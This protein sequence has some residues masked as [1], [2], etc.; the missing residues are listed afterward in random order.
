MNDYAARRSSV[1]ICEIVPSRYFV[2][3]ARPWRINSKTCQGRATNRPLMFEDAATIRQIVQDEWQVI[4]QAPINFVSAIILGLIGIWLFLRHQYSERLE[5]TKHTLQ[6]ITAQRDSYRE[7]REEERRKNA[8]LIDRLNTSANAANNMDGTRSDGQTSIV[9]RP[10]TTATE[11][12]HLRYR[13]EALAGRGIISRWVTDEDGTSFN[14]GGGSNTDDRL[15]AEVLCR[16]AGMLLQNS[17]QIYE[18]LSATVKAETDHLRRWLVWIKE[19]DAIQDSVTGESREGAASRKWT[20]GTI[21][22]LIRSSS[23][24]CTECMIAAST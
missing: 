13:F 21:N 9:S 19:K 20:G 18:S 3:K 2:T 17:G 5:T 4:K 12:A 7:D 6:M 14:I 11:W 23:R 24:T 16:N 8:L 15:D 1:V 10:V 22:D